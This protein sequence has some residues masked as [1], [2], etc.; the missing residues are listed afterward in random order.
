MSLDT[1]TPIAVVSTTCLEVPP[2]GYGGLELMVYNLCHELGGR[3]YDVTCIAPQGTDIE[4][5][6]VI[7]TTRPSDSDACFRKEP[8]AFQ[9]YA[10]RLG[11]FDLVIDHSWQKLSYTKQALDPA[12]MR[13]TT[14]LGVWHRVPNF[15]PV[16]VEEPNLCAVSKAAARATSQRLGQ[17]VRHA[18]NG[19]DVDRYPLQE[20][21]DDYLLTLNR[22]MPNKGVIECIDVA[23]ELGYPLKVVGEDKFLGNVEYVAEVMRRCATSECAEY[24]GQVD[25]GTKRSLLQGARA[26]LLLPQAPY[27]EAFGLAAVEGMATGTPVL[28]T[29]NGGLAE[30]VETVQGRGAYDN[31]NVLV[32][33]LERVVDGSGRFPDATE[34]RAG[35]EEHFSTAR[36]ADMYL[37]RGEE[38]I[39]EGW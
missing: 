13:E 36:M 20:S 37:Q 11:D 4:G 29:A 33:D 26:L 32:A 24:V 25:H 19:I 34:L 6:D 8:Q 16:P 9:Q 23:E 5:F 18:Y 22:V 21:K 10:D 39:T 28:A 30:V 31:L 35:V 17:E 27:R 38:A 15:Q 12:G 1:D 2:T 14:I 7:E 3:G